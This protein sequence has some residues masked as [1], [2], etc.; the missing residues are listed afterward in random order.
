MALR[1][2]SLADKYALDTTRAY[3][4]GMRPWCAYPF[5]SIS[6]TRSEA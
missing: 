3:L 4:T 5:F 2:V 6:A 1:K